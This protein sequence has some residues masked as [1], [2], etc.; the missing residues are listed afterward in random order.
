VYLSVYLSNR[1]QF[2]KIG[3]ASSPSLPCTSRVPQG[4]VFGP[5]LFSLY[6]SPI[7]RFISNHCVLYH[8]Y[9]DDNVLYTA[10]F[11]DSQ[12]GLDR[13]T[14]CSV[15]L[16]HWFLTHALL[17]NPTK[18]EA[19]YFGTRQRLDI[20]NLPADNVVAKSHIPVHEHLKIQG[21]T[22]DRRL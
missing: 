22:I 16:Q 21:V 10:L 14:N 6:I 4:S 7:S 3:N 20:F 19:S 11:K 15:H 5:L 18:S 12:S 2:V 8:C 9:A 13:L 17:L 1:S